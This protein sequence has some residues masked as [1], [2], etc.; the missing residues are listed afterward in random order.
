MVEPT[1][2]KFASLEEELCFW[3]EQAE[4]HQQRYGGTH[5]GVLTGVMPPRP[6]VDSFLLYPQYL[7]HSTDLVQSAVP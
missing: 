3:K 6:G 4:R 1:T 2:H 7:G 5:E